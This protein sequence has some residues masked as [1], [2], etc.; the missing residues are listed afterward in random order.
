MTWNSV[1]IIAHNLIHRR[2]A[3]LVVF[4]PTGTGNYVKIALR[5]FVAV[6]ESLMKS[7]ACALPHVVAHKVIPKIW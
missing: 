1:K 5:H 3:E 4:L 2:C 6:E 7:M